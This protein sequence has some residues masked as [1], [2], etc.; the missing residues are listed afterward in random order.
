MILVRRIVRPGNLRALLVRMVVPSRRRTR[1]VNVTGRTISRTEVAFEAGQDSEG[2][3][4][5][6]LVLT[7]EGRPVAGDKIFTFDLVPEL[8]FR[9]VDLLVG[10][11]NRCVTHL[12][13][14][15]P[16]SDAAQGKGA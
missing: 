4:V 15:A 6:A 11:L 13:M 7:R 1:E 8:T 10:A 9:E 5:I 3:L 2:R 12:G 14:A 16:K